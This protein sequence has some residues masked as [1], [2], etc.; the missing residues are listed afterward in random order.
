MARKEVKLRVRLDGKEE[1]KAE[2]DELIKESGA[3]NLKFD[4]SSAIKSLN[5]FSKVL[6]DVGRKIQGS[7]NSSQINNEVQAIFL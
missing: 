4:T 2:L 3:N 6:D 1:F 7:F 5:E